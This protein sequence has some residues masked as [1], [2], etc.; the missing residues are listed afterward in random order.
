M[1]I[2]HI[3][4]HKMIHRIYMLV[5][6]YY[7]NLLDS[8][9][10]NMLDYQQEN[11]LI[12]N[13]FYFQLTV[14]HFSDQVNMNMFHIHLNLNKI[15]NHIDIPMKLM[16]MEHFHVIYIDM[17][18]IH[19]HLLHNLISGRRKKKYFMI[20]KSSSIYQDDMEDMREKL[21]N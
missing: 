10:P 9:I 20:N 5:Q 21:N 16:Y 3:D 4:D 13:R 11:D 19:Q 1:L 18:H 2:Y 14:K 17:F 15:H 6:I 12:S 7:E 8:I